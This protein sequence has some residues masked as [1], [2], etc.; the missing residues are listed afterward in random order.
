LGASD[1]Y[2][3]SS[4]WEG[5][6]VALLEAMASGLPGVVTDVGDTAQVFTSEMGRLV[7]ARQPHVLAAA[8]CDLLAQPENWPQMGAAAREA[9]IAGY[10]AEVAAKQLLALYADIHKRL[11]IED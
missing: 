1:I 6:S 5:L 2:V 8:L 4:W 9:I 11:K 10:S 7:P 3:S